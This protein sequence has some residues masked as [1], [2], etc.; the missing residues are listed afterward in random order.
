MQPLVNEDTNELF[1]KKCVLLFKIH[2][3]YSSF[4]I[5]SVNSFIVDKL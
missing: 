1:E 2:P 3:Y 4:F 5:L